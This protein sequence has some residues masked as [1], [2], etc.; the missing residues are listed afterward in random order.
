M[1]GA[2]FDGPRSEESPLQIAREHTRGESEARR[3]DALDGILQAV[4]W[5]QRDDRRKNLLVDHLHPWAR[6]ADNGR[7]QYRS[8]A[9]STKSNV[10]LVT[11]RFG[12][13][14][15]SPP[16][17]RLRNHRPHASRRISRIACANGGRLQS[18]SRQNLLLQRS[19][20]I[21]PLNRGADLACLAKRSAGDLRNR[22]IQIGVRADDGAG[23]A[24]KLELSA[25]QSGSGLDQAADAGTASEGVKI[26]PLLVQQPASD[27]AVAMHECQQIWRQTGF[28]KEVT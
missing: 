18:E 8:I 12:E 1:D 2:D 22:R 15:L 3:I 27:F 19:L 4:D 17:V 10:R 9:R 25:A 11:C 20:N 14:S 7:L 23:D 5:Q 28:K 26:D 24:A 16:G 6:P 13:P 21:E